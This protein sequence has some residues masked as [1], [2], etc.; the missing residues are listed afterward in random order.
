VNNLWTLKAL[1]RG[2]EM[3]SGLKVNFHK[4]FLM[5]V[6]VE[7]E[8]LNMASDFLNCN[9]RE[10]PRK[11]STWEPLLCQLRKRL[12]S[13]GNKYVSLGG[14][15]VL[16][17]SVLNAI[18]IFY[19]SF[20]K[21]PTK[22]VRK[23]IGIQ[24]NFLWGGKVGGRKI[25][26]VKWSRVCSPW[27]EGGLGVRDIK[28]VN[29]SLLAKW[30]WR[31]LGEDDQVWKWV[32]KEKYGERVYGVMD[33]SSES[34]PSYASL[35]WKDLMALEVFRGVNS[36]NRE[37]VRKVRNDISMKFWTDPWVGG[38]PLRVAFSRLYSLST[39]KEAVVSELCVMVEG[40]GERRF[41][42]RRDLFVWEL[43]LVNDLLTCIGVFEEIGECD[44]WVWM[45][46][47]GVSFR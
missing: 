34:W 4:S 25:W 23:I 5:G 33:G 9:K 31:L 43:G 18:P 2:F 36:F 37:V 7:M 3:V 42:W 19:L 24:R 13:W 46:R 39:Q 29:L 20:L 8:F 1:L 35:W 32:L 10:I 40:G 28:L 44:S 30:R 16:L 27:K 22:V 21:M 6:N 14:R 45:L 38:L 12:C 11:L 15:I 17:N 47:R 26:W 41:L